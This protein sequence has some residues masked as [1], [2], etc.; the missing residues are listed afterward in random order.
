M[1]VEQLNVSGMLRNRHL[2]RAVSDAGLAQLRRLLGYKAT[3]R[4][5][6]LV[7]ADP[8]YPSSK[9]CSACGAARATL[10]LGER[11][12]RCDNDGCGLVLD[13]DLNAARNLARLV[14]GLEA[15]ESQNLKD[16][17]AAGSGPEAQNARGVGVRPGLVGRTATNREAGTGCCPGQAGTVG[18]QASAA[19]TTGTR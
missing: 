10:R 7:E 19:R 3:W 15:I 4:G 9:T 13:R 17:A 5:A 11:T 18:A 14:V 6:R 16:P 12:F 2:A 1:V 8:F